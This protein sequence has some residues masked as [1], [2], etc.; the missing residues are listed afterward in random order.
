MIKLENEVEQPRRVV[1]QLELV[2]I[3]N[4]LNSALANWTQQ[5]DQLYVAFY[6]GTHF[7]DYT[8]GS[9][10]PGTIRKSLKPK[11]SGY[12]TIT[13]FTT[14]KIFTD[15]SRVYDALNTPKLQ[16]Y[17]FKLKLIESRE[18]IIKINEALVDSM[19]RLKK[20]TSIERIKR[21]LS[22]GKK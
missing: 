5:D 7:S 13:D 18:E 14:R 16:E 6:Q 20:R 22:F 8:A 9:S 1:E 10:S 12:L 11:E 3:T 2:S 19:A 15:S 17:D 21:A 4:R